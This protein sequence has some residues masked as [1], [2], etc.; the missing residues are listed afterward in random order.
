LLCYGR[1]VL[2]EDLPCTLSLTVSGG[3][4]YPS[5]AYSKDKDTNEVSLLFNKKSKRSSEVQQ[6]TVVS[7]DWRFCTT[8]DWN[9]IGEINNS[10][11]IANNG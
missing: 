9:V 4:G 6:A 3:L 1:K 11:Q 8:Y 7:E 2:F 10:K 5:K